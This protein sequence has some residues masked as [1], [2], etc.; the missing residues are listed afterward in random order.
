MTD[1]V[2][3]L[4]SLDRKSDK[5]E[6]PWVV[7]ALHTQNPLW[8]SKT[9]STYIG[10]SNDH[11]R[12]LRQHNGEIAKGAKKTIKKRPWKKNFVVSSF[13]TEVYAL[14]FEWKWNNQKKKYWNRTKEADMPFGT[15]VKDRCQRLVWMFGRERVVQKAPKL[16]SQTY[17]V[18]CALSEKE[19][20]SHISMPISELRLKH[21]HVT[22]VFDVVF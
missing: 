7:Y 22:Y 17:T 6:K 14:Q 19:F 12:R 3:F 21:P 9:Y 1:E 11:D 16:H 10:A 5:T 20:C 15:Q 18:Q 13:A 4:D 8:R 2:L